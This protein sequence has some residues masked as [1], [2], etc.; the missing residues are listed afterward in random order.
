MLTPESILKSTF[1]YDTFKPLQ[2]EIINNVHGAPR[3]ARHHANRRRQVAHL[4]SA[5]ADDGRA[6]R[7]RLAFDRVDERSGGAIARVGRAAVFLNSSL[8]SE[9]YQENMDSVK[10]G[11]SKLLYVAPETLLTPRIYSLLS[12]L[13]LDLLAIDEAHCISEWGHDF[14][15]E[16]RQLVDVR[17]KFPPPCA[18]HSPPPPPRE[19]GRYCGLAWLY[20]EE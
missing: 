17:R 18:W 2:R 6:H 20:R 5:R 4:P 8:S 3:Y 12:S 11:Q 1:G 16:Y 7:C 19:S 9:E 10:S 14:R 13:K 15:P